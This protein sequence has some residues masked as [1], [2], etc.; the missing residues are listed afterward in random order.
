MTPG[1]RLEHYK[2]MLEEL[3]NSEETNRYNGYCQ[4]ALNHPDIL[5]NIYDDKVFEKT[6][7]ELYLQKPKPVMTFWFSY[8]NYTLRIAPV[9]KAI[10]LVKEINN[11]NNNN[12]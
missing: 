5:L 1:Q 7:P 6:Y 8:G 3:E 2:I 11:N 12:N 4:M 10:K 9:K